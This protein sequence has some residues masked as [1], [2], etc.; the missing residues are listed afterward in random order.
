MR[1]NDPDT[2]EARFDGP[3]PGKASGAKMRI[4]LGII[5]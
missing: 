4:I 2:G 5:F 1:G 3:P